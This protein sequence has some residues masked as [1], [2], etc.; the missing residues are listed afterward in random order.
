MNFL[1][2]QSLYRSVLIVA[3]TALTTAC[4]SSAEKAKGDTVGVGIKSLNYSGKEVSYI[5]VEKPED[6][7]GGGGGDALNPYSGGG[8]TICCFSIPNKWSPD[9]KVVIE[10][11]FYPETTYRKQLVSV[12]P[13]A[14]GKLGDIW[15]IVHPDESVEAVVSDFGP[16]RDEWPGKI[17]G[18]PV[19]SREYQLKRWKEKLQLENDDLIRFEQA[20]KN[21]NL[22][23]DK[24][25]G[26]IET[27]NQIKKSISNLES[28][29]P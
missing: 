18:Y 16:T 1:S 6:P 5:A 17:K 4:A 23:K 11:Q 21:P 10:Y 29:R 20:V 2:N 15:L 27:I 24:R 26:Y 12:A 8:S 28:N 14:A 19:P 22:P 3:M 25:D 13:Y 7:N 9:L